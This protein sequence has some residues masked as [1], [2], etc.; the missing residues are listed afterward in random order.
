M[1]AAQINNYGSPDSFYINSNAADPV[2]SGGKIIVEAKAASINPFDIKILQGSFKAMMPLTFPAVLGG[3]F[4][5]VV[6]ETGAN[7]GGLKAGDEVFGTANIF[8]GGSGAFAGMLLA[9]SNNVALKPGNLSFEQSAALPLVGSSAV[10]ALEEHFKLQAGQKILIQ[11]GAG[12]IGHIAIQVAKA[13]GA[14]VITTVSPDDREFAEK[15]GADQ[16]INYK[17][18]DFTKIL[19]DLDCVFDTVGGVLTN[20]SLSVI[21]RGGI[22]VT[23]IGEPDQQTAKKTGVTAIRQASKNSTGH[24]NRVKQLV[25]EG[26]IKVNIDKIFSLDQIKEAFKH[27]LE[28]HP[29]GKVVLKIRD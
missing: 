18:E 26:K 29:R 13:L 15:L 20:K 4:S 9:N 6:K 19:K 14:F 16:V 5:G 3:D 17:Q 1:K 22:L 2:L 23:M 27:Q 28:N 8:S 25:E 10:Q 12:G 7:T 21:K 24:L 11:G